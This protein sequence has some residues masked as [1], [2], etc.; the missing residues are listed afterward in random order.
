MMWTGAV[1][2]RALVTIAMVV[3][4]WGG[5]KAQDVSPVVHEG[6]VEAPLDAVWAAWTTSAGLQ[7][8][9]APHAE[10]DLRVGGRMRANYNA[11][12][13]LGDPQTIENTVLSFDPQRMLSIK[14]ARSPAGF[15]FPNAIQ[16]MWSIIYL[17][18][19]APGRTRVREVSL[20]F[21]TDEESQKM[22]AFFNQGNATT[23]HQLQR[24]FA[25][26]SAQ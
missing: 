16:R 7:S 14:V 8:W 17:E 9:M 15:P 19:V 4:S 10:I 23:L 3:V 21:E 5:A 6:I 1:V 24:R 20:G 18:A 12:G 11:Q 2:G 13:T 22:R 25:K 26:A